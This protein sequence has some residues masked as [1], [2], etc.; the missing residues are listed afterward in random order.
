[1]VNDNEMM[2]TVMMIV[3]MMMLMIFMMT[4]TIDNNGDGLFA[5]SLLG[6]QYGFTS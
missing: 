3:I 5:S 2:I 6:Q 1:M 4:M